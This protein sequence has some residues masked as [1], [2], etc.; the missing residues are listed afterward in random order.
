MGGSVAPSVPAVGST[1]SVPNVAPAVGGVVGGVLPTVGSLPAVGAVV[2]AVG[3]VV[4]GV[5]GGGGIVPS[6]P[7]GPLLPGGTPAL[8]V[9]NVPVSND[10]GSGPVGP[11]TPPVGKLLSCPFLFNCLRSAGISKY[12]YKACTI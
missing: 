10:Y 9:P 4:G 6:I 2:P 1:P 5:V 11:I 8:P 12:A 7:G 3:G